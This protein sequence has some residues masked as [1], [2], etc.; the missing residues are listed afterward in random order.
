MR[1]YFLMMCAVAAGLGGG[2]VLAADVELLLESG[3]DILGN[4]IHYPDGGAPM[5][6]GA[7]ATLAP[8]ECNGW[9]KHPVPTLG[10]MLTGTLTISYETGEERRIGGGDAIIEAQDTRHQG[11]NSGEDEVRIIVF[12]AGAEGEPVTIAD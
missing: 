11:C 6:T 2:P 5:I 3:D 7:L 8:G 1:G 10:Y 12:Y 4:P 9:H